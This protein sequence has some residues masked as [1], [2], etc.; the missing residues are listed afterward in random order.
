HCLE[1]VPSEDVQGILAGDEL[2]QSPLVG[3]PV[4]RSNVFGLESRAA[5]LA[6]LPTGNK[7]VESLECLAIIH[8]WIRRMLLIEIDLVSAESS[9]TFLHRP[10]DLA[11]P[12]SREVRRTA[13]C[14]RRVAELRG[15]DR[16]IAPATQRFAEELLGS[17][18][19]VNVCG[20]EEVD[21]AVQRGA[22]N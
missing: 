16:L 8:R 6:H 17:T 19:P 14:A 18:I 13:I 4:G 15:D 12:G 10:D 9:E 20:V 5:D 21:A 2:C 11:P 1:R 7:R 3:D 22:Y